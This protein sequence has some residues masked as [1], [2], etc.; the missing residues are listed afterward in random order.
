MRTWQDPFL[1]ILSSW[2]LIEFAEIILLERQKKKKKGRRKK[3]KKQLCM[4]QKILSRSLIYDKGI[5]AFSGEGWHPPWCFE[6]KPRDTCCHSALEVFFFLIFFSP[7]G[8]KSGFE[9]EAFVHPRGALA[10]LQPP[11]GEG[12]EPLPA[13]GKLWEARALWRL[14]WGRGCTSPG[15]GSR[16][17]ARR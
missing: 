2:T 16:L 3:K 13:C 6:C 1:Y 5:S 14:S 12:E 7:D 17:G 4:M 8:N 15:G 11:A 9:L 10:P